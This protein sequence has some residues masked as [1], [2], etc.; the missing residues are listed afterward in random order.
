V[1]GDVTPRSRMMMMQ[2]SGMLGF[3]QS[4]ELPTHHMHNAFDCPFIITSSSSSLKSK[5]D[6]FMLRISPS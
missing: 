5:R 6:G 1:R 3:E 2:V 4:R